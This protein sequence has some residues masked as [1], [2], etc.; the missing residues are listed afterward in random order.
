M[1]GFI[2]KLEVEFISNQHLTLRS[3]L[4]IYTY[5]VLLQALKRKHALVTV[6]ERDTDQSIER[7]YILAGPMNFFAAKSGAVGD[8]RK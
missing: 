8:S 5:R 2:S 4:K 1:W 7:V 3:V 6:I